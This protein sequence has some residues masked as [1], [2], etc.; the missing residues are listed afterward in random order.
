[1]WTAKKAG[2]PA[3]KQQPPK[4]D[5]K[6]QKDNKRKK[7]ASEEATDE[8]TSSTSDGK[9]EQR[10]RRDKTRIRIPRHI[11]IPPRHEPVRPGPVTDTP[12]SSAVDNTTKETAAPAKAPKDTGPEVAPNFIS[13]DQKSAFPG[14][15]P[16]AARLDPTPAGPNQGPAIVD[17]IPVVPI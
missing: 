5:P 12:R 1:M 10:D 15:K 8:D 11:P 16:A 3:P 6:T 2:V 13:K 9:R 4:E 7:D 17:P 14:Q